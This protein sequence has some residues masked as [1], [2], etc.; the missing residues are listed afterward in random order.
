MSSKGQLS[1]SQWIR[2]L[3]IF[4]ARLVLEVFGGA[5]AIWGFSEAL[6]LRNPTNSVPLWRPIALSFGFIFFCRWILQIQ[7]FVEESKQTVPEKEPA[8]GETGP[9]MYGSGEVAWGEK[10]PSDKRAA[11]CSSLRMIWPIGMAINVFKSSF[12]YQ[13]D[14]LSSFEL[15]NLAP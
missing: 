7:D 3:Q 12:M 10:I 6:G 14:N 13:Q 1:N 8:N 15:W 2:L 9:L 4:S 5:G 11:M